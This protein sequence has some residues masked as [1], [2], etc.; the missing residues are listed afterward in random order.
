MQPY[1][2]A[3]AHEGGCKL[4]KKPPAADKV[5]HP[6]WQLRPLVQIPGCH[7]GQLALPACSAGLA[8]A[9]EL[10]AVRFRAD[11]GL[12]R[13]RQPH[14]ALRCGE[15]RLRP[16]GPGREGAQEGV[17]EAPRGRIG[18]CA[19]AAHGAGCARRHEALREAF[20]V[21]GRE[22][23]DVE[24]R[25]T[26]AA[27]LAGWLGPTR[28]A[29][30]ELRDVLLMDGVPPAKRVLQ[31]QRSPCLAGLLRHA[32]RGEAEHPPR[33]LPA[34]CTPDLRECPGRGGA[35]S[36]AAAPLEPQQ[37]LQLSADVQL[38]GTVG[39]R[40]EVLEPKPGGRRLAGHATQRRTRAELHVPW[41]ARRLHGALDMRTPLCQPLRETPHRPSC[42]RAQHH[43]I[44]EH[45][46]E[47]HQGDSATLDRAV[48]A[49]DTSMEIQVRHPSPDDIMEGMQK[50]V[51]MLPAQLD[52]SL[53]RATCTAVVSLAVRSQ[54]TPEQVAASAVLD[55]CKE[56]RRLHSAD[57]RPAGRV[58]KRRENEACAVQV[59]GQHLNGMPAAAQCV[60][61]SP[62][63]GRQ[64][65]PEEAVE[66]EVENDAAC[67]LGARSR[68][69]AGPAWW[70]QR[71]RGR[72]EEGLV[73]RWRPL[74][75]HVPALTPGHQ[76]VRGLQQLRE[77][78]PVPPEGRW[79][80]NSFK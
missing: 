17:E 55:H 53:A 12:L 29:G 69:L 28:R 26:A 33:R 74:H 40:V 73:R 23:D 43:L 68:G 24:G 14:C 5:L 18:D 16:A 79:L 50:T 2:P 21:A 70:S 25:G 44:T 19:T 22:D 9:Q 76:D 39:R 66:V 58:S 77:L 72:Y 6:R 71:Q 31:E 11:V 7:R 56:L 64:Q 49:V 62:D 13:R 67:A 15:G 4:R 38:L 41:S 27:A 80:P 46:M 61:E 47:I 30:Q 37:G 35:H 3:A 34:P 60:Q 8:A 75:G 42:V 57:L 52:W 63:E 48:R 78:Q 20:R 1:C 51:Y 59:H 54:G 65:A 36:H 32:V 45:G 10:E